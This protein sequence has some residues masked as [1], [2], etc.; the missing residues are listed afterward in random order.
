[1]AAQ[2]TTSPKELKAQSTLWNYIA[3]N[4]GGIGVMIPPDFEMGIRW[5]SMKNNHRIL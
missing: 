3:V 5:V 2:S 1:M 4:P